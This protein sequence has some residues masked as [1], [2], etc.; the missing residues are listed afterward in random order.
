M[1][2]YFNEVINAIIY[3]GKPIYVEINLKTGLPLEYDLN[4]KLIKKLH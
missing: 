1:S 2:L 4:R 3:A